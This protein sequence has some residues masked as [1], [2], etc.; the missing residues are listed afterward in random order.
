M[1]WSK[2]VVR[3]TFPNS[4][5]WPTFPTPHL[6]LPRERGEASHEAIEDVERDGH[7]E[8]RDLEVV[9]GARVDVTGALLWNTVALVPERLSRVR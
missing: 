7:D 9:D 3:T 6:V 2:I 1:M 4:M 5:V 8:P